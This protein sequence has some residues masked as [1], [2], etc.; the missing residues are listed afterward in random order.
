LTVALE[1]AAAAPLDIGLAQKIDVAKE[2]EN[3]DPATVDLSLDVEPPQPDSTTSDQTNAG[4][5]SQTS[6]L[7]PMT[8][9][10]KEPD[11][12]QSLFPSRY[13]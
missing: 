3:F 1:E 10:E 4:G 5:L 13:A 9:Q 7:A 6:Q 8:N 2:L 12:L 11:R